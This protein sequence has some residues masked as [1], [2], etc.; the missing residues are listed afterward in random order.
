MNPRKQMTPEQRKLLHDISVLDF[1]VVEMTLFLDTHPDNKE[2]M[3]Y[4]SQYI[5]MKNRASHEYAL[6]Y[7]PLTI[8]EAAYSVQAR[9]WCWN[10]GPM[11]WEGGC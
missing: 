3:D 11:P 10:D 2:A 9:D 5:R 4:I 6:K 8:D 1:V 7:E